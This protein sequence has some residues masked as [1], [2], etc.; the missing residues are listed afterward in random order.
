MSTLYF[1]AAALKAFTAGCGYEH[2]AAHGR[3]PSYVPAGERGWI[4]SEETIAFNYYV[5]GSDIENLIWSKS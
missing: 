2:A 1:E 3:K 5:R 4:V